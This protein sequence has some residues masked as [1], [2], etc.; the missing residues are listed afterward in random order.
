MGIEGFG[1]WNNQGT[2]LFLSE[3]DLYLCDR[4]CIFTKMV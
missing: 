3:F 2:E 1:N 4:V